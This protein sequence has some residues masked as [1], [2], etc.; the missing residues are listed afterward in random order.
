[1]RQK[2]L[3]AYYDWQ[4][5]L[6]KC[7]CSSHVDDKGNPLSE[8]LVCDRERKFRL[9]CQIRDDIISKLKIR[10]VPKISMKD[11]FTYAE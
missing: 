3:Y 6:G 2:L 4:R 1:M 9:Y 5:A 8:H 10:G 7:H 11:V